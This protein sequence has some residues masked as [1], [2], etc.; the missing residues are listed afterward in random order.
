MRV[1][2]GAWIAKFVPRRETVEPSGEGTPGS[3]VF[4]HPV[5]TASRASMPAGF[6][7]YRAGWN[8][9]AAELMQ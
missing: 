8:A 4:A 9:S 6:L 7:L 2:A 1:A 5:V 3:M